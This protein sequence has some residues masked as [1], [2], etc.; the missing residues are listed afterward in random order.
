MLRT[1]QA[2]VMT[3][4]VHKQNTKA[5][6]AEKRRSAAQNRSMAYISCGRMVVKYLYDFCAHAQ[7]AG[8]TNHAQRRMRCAEC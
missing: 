4:N 1:R 3:A 5:G 2:S 6:K 7:V 8:K